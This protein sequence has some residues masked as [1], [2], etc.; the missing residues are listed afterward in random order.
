MLLGHFYIPMVELPQHASQL[1]VL[2]NYKN[3]EMNF[4]KNYELNLLTPYLGGYLPAL[5]FSMF[6]DIV[7]AL[8]LTILISMVLL[9]LAMRWLL[10]TTGGE[11]WWSLLG[12]SI[13]T[14][15]S[16]YYGFVSFLFATPFLILTLCLCY[17]Y[18]QNL[19]V[20]TGWQICGLATVVFVIHGYSF[21]LLWLIS[22]SLQ[23]IG[24]A[25]ERKSFWKAIWPFILPVFLALIWRLTQ[26][27][28]IDS[29]LY[30]FGGLIR[31][32]SLPGYLIEIW[33]SRE[34][35]WVVFACFATLMIFTCSITRKNLLVY[36]PLIVS[37]LIFTFLPD[38]IFGVSFLGPR[39][40]V[41]VFTFIF[42][43]VKFSDRFKTA[44]IAIIIC[45]A[46]I[47]P[48]YNSLRFQQFNDH[49]KSFDKII[50]AV[51]FDSTVV[52]L[53]QQHQFPDMSG[54]YFE[55]FKSYI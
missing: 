41:L 21:V 5:F 19:K 51:P 3:T 14:S 49:V 35:S 12:F 33:P 36:I 42:I 2:I 53:D 37:L 17:K 43:T 13:F 38:H 20:K 48:V 18:I 29:R 30:Y 10:K 50:D 31:L 25:R 27:Q 15:Y 24:I 28:I 22:Q 40:S 16:F 34:K 26:D 23:L 4:V 32:Y 7:V 8:K 54:F 55:H 9:C 1:S 46:F 45:A 11:C 44:K 39:L 47:C 52:Q 6:M